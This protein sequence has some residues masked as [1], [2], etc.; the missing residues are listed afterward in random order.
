M[1]SD[2]QYLPSPLSYQK[3][4]GC[5]E[6]ISIYDVMHVEGDS[7]TKPIK[8]YCRVDRSTSEISQLSPSR[9]MN[10]HLTRN[11]EGGE[12]NSRIAG[13]ALNENI[14]NYESLEPG[15]FFRG[16]ITGDEE[17]LKKFAG[18]MGLMDGSTTFDIRIGRSK[19]TQ[20]GKARMTF[21]DVSP[22]K[23]EG[24]NIG[25]G[26]KTRNDEFVIAFVSHAIFNN[27]YGFPDSSVN[28][29]IRYLSN[30]LGI[31][32][33]VLKIE[34]AF[35]RSLDIESFLSVWRLRQP[36]EKAVSAGSCF[37]VKIEGGIENNIKV[38]LKRLG[39]TGIGERRREG[40]GRF[41]LDPDELKGGFGS[42]KPDDEEECKPGGPMPDSVKN[43]IEH[44]VKKRLHSLA[45]A[46]AVKDARNFGDRPSNSLLGRLANILKGSISDDVF[47]G[48]KLKKLR[49]TALG[50]LKKCWN[51]N[52]RNDC[53]NLMKHLE[54]FKMTWEKIYGFENTKIR[55]QLEELKSSA[56]ITIDEKIFFSLYRHYWETFF[57]A[58]RKSE[59]C[60][61]GNN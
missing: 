30:E 40:Y 57:Y 22:V 52:N 17:T 13:T 21:L 25:S 11:K 34:K 50:Q 51:D 6:D 48:Q 20:Y 24:Y 12:F 46:Q 26:N 36:S 59:K 31:E 47:V 38:S 5:D 8:G 15:Q 37:K 10:F 55:T 33:N 56:D 23:F 41:V 54:S 3:E 32:R 39:A 18:A 35:S 60:K 4:K 9:R 7:A 2:K 44:M 19:G 49:E 29:L 61:G 28:G 16:T 53:I 1:D 58:M 43:V 42:K 14:F 27:Q 45:G